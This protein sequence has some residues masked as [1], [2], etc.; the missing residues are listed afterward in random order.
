M[1]PNCV[2]SDWVSYEDCQ[3]LKNIL[4]NGDLVQ[5]QFEGDSWEHWGVV[6]TENLDG[7]PYGDIHLV[8][9]GAEKVTERLRRS[10]QPDQFHVD[11]PQF[12]AMDEAC[13]DRRI[14]LA[15]RGHLANHPDVCDALRKSSAW[16]DI[17]RNVRI[18]PIDYVW[19]GSRCRR[20][21]FR[22]DYWT[23]KSWDEMKQQIRKEMHLNK[24]YS[25]LGN[26]AE[27]LA[28]RLRYGHNY[29]GQVEMFWKRAGSMLWF[30]P[31]SMFK[32]ISEKIS[33]QLYG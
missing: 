33:G 32:F 27:M 6:M 15:V 4:H 17:V 24:P 30:V 16:M 19:E 10:E 8:H 2:T 26:N 7:E 21:N 31:Q 12:A 18:D 25:P 9:L 20:H 29:S 11:H 13:G 22:N 1:D 5:I 3:R 14:G 23:P 28:H